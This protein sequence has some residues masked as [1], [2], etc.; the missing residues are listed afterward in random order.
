[1]VDEQLARRD[2]TDASV[3]AA[4]RSVPRH[5]FVPGAALDEAY[6]DRPLPIGHGATISQPYIVALMTQALAVTPRDRVL[7]IGTGSGYGAAILAELAAEVVTVERVTPLARAAAERLAHLDHVRVVA[8]D[9]ADPGTVGGLFDAIS[10][11]AATP[12][13]PT[14]LLEH[15][16]PGGRLVA[17][18]GSD[19]ADLVR[20][21]R[22]STGD[23]R[24][25][26]T[27]VRFVPLRRGVTD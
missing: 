27:K 22:S 16:A 4:M 10:V 12:E 3:L 25:T 8:G 13:L 2:I 17:P 15:L 14:A 20:V 5:E 21:T 7:E 6:D 19:V 9:G 23:A 26:L 24:E 18:V 11:T 1:M